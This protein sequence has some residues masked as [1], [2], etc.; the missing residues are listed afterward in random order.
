MA[1]APRPAKTRYS[2]GPNEPVARVNATQGQGDPVLQ[3]RMGEITALADIESDEVSA[4][5]GLLPVLPLEI[6]LHGTSLSLFSVISTFGTPQDVT[7]DELRVEAFYPS[8]EATGRF[9]REMA[10][11]H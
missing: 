6:D 4:A 9:F 1:S 10:A 11:I 7:T 2:N 5:Q 8:D 3:A